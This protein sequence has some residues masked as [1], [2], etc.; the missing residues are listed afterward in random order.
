MSSKHKQIEEHLLNG[1]SITGLSA[2]KEFGVYRLS[3]VI[4]RLRKKGMKIHTQM[5]T[6]EYNSFAKYKMIK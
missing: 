1:G 5:I 3:S 2:M 6:T 4:E